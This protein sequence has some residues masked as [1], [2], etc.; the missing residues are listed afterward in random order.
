MSFS[1]NPFLNVTIIQRPEGKFFLCNGCGGEKELAE[2]SISTAFD[3]A[4]QHVRNSHKRT[5]EDFHNSP[6]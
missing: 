3:I 5:P 2:D 4:D 1:A 6:Y